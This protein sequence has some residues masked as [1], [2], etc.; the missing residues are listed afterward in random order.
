MKKIGLSVSK[1][2]IIAKKLGK[3]FLDKIIENPYRLLELDI[4]IKFETVD[5]IAEI[6]KFDMN[7]S[8]RKKGMISYILDEFTMKNG[9]TYILYDELNDKLKYKIDLSDDEYKEIIRDMLLSKMIFIENYSSEIRIYPYKLY[10]YECLISDKIKLLN[11]KN[12]F[13]Y[14]S[15]E[16]VIN[17]YEHSHKLNL[18]TLQKDAIIKA[19]NS[20]FVVITGGPGTGKTTLI[21]VILDFFKACDKSIALAA[22]TACAAKRMEDVCGYNASTIHRLLELKKTDEDEFALFGRNKDNPLDED[23]LIVDEAS[24]IDV[25]LMKSLL[26]AVLPTSKLIM[27]GDKNQLP[28]VGIGNILSDIITSD[29]CTVIELSKVY[30]QSK[31]KSRIIEVAS[32]ILNSEPITIDNPST[33]DD[34]FIVDLDDFDFENRLLSYIKRIS[35]Q[36]NIDIDEIQ[37]LS[38]Q[39]LGD[40]GVDKINELLQKNLNPQREFLESRYSKTFFKL[41][42]RVIHTKNN[43]YKEY[44]LS[45]GKIGYGVFNGECGVV[46][47]IDVFN[48]YLQVEYP[49]KIV[50]Y[51][52]D[53]INDLKLSYCITIHKSQG[54][55]YKSVIIVLGTNMSDLL[56]DRRLLYTAITRAKSLVLI[57]TKKRILNEIITN[58]N[59]R[60][61]NTGLNIKLRGFNV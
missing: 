48:E 41:N 51:Y 36:L 13:D 58:N 4:G 56:K 34:L 25:Y 6:V 32:Q 12:N 21:Q 29:A 35:S 47:D 43:Y 38:P 33:E 53:E 28:S 52:G 37:L 50:S 1:Y 54:S 24:M 17:A 27:V 60:I 49:D 42:D 45:N 10:K 22:P 61:R 31:N 7:S 39:S 9:H 14:N 55:E 26:D 30:R 5:N 40:Y 18:D 2:E 57:I 19:I 46:I 15:I 59:I 23:V 16:K 11:Y 3:N 44:E 8:Y 20:N